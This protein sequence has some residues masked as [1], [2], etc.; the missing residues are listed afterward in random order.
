V[1]VEDGDLARVAREGHGQ[2]AAGVGVPEQDVGHGVAAFLARQPRFQD[3]GHLVGHPGERQ[4]AP[5]DEHQHDRCA[6]RH[7][8]ADQVFLHAG[9][10]ELG[11]IARFAGGAVSSQP[12]LVAHD[13]D[14]DRRLAGDAH[15]FIEAGRILAEHVAAL[16]VAHLGR[17][18]YLGLDALQDAHHIDR[19]L[20]QRDIRERRS[21]EHAG[22]GRFGQRLDVGRVGIVAHQVAQA[23]RVGADHRDGRRVLGERQQAALVLQQDTRLA[24]DL[25]GQRALLGRVENR[26]GGPAID[27]RVLEQAQVEFPGQYPAHGFVDQRQFDLAVFDSLTQRLAVAVDAGQ[28]DVDPGLHRHHRGLAL[29]PRGLVVGA[30][31]ID[32][33]VVRDHQ[34]VEAQLV[35]QQR[36]EDLVGRGAGDP[37][38]LVVGVHDRRE[39]AFLDRRF[40]RHEEQLAQLAP[41]HVAGRPVHPAFGHAIAEKVLAGRHDAGFEIAALQPDDV[42]GAHPRGEVGV[43]TERFFGAAPAGIARDVQHGR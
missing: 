33:V 25:A 19:V 1:I 32:R 17:G 40:E 16:R 30:D 22:C 38:Q 4:R 41:A 29:V 5:G 36:P 6:R 10:A 2:L 3:G 12:G 18:G 34:T 9:Q 14:G 15:G 7:H 42:G 13:Q 24:R 11:P 26:R 28:L 23:V 8:R 37:I 39:L 31:H 21:L 43:L 27:V 20:D 35:A